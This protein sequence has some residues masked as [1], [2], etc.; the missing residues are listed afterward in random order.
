M[1]KI[2][3]ILFLSQ[4]FLVCSS[5]ENKFPQT[6]ISNG[7]LEVNFYLPDINNGYY[8]ATRFDWSGNTTSLTYKGHS[9]YGQWYNKYEP[10]IHDVV[11]GP[12]EEFGPVGFEEAGVGGNFIKIGVGAL[13]KPDDKPYNSFRLYD[14]K[15]PGKWKIRKKSS[16]VTFIQTISDGDYGY[17]YIKT[18]R[19]AEGSPEM[20]I[21]HTLINNGVKRIETSVYNHNFLMIDKE[22]TGPGYS[23]TFPFE[24]SGDCRGTGETIQFEGKQMKFLRNLTSSENIFCGNLGGFK[25][26]PDNYNIKVENLKTGA[27]VRITSRESLSKLVFWASPTTVCP[28]PYTDIEVEPGSRFSWSINYEYFLTT[29]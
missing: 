4:S 10:T 19:L 29:K 3:I 27:G 26:I 23:I 5:Q 6:G 11:M 14:I 13:M 24:L 16:S 18:V 25:G 21:E 7:I 20:I 8:R 15:N 17:T 9:Y 12:V 22:P 1:K 28:E 2:C